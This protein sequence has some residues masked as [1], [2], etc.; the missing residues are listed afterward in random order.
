MQIDESPQIQQR[1]SA[2]PRPRLFPILE[3]APG[4]R[5]GHTLTTITG[6]DGDV[7][8]AKLVLFGVFKF[9]YPHMWDGRAAHAFIPREKAVLIIATYNSRLQEGRLLWRAPLQRTQTALLRDHLDLQL[10]VSSSCPCVCSPAV[11]SV[12]AGKPPDSVCC[13]CCRHPLGWCNQ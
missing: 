13:C 12:L 2:V 1:P 7:N 9:K 6:P 5:C 11:E 4:P 8:K 3:N 10:L